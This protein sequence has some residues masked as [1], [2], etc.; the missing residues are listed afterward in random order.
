MF[1]AWYHHSTVTIH[2][3]KWLSHTNRYH[4]QMFG[5]LKAPPIKKI[6]LSNTSFNIKVVSHSSAVF[7]LL[8]QTTPEF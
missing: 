8:D 1:I 5:F 3:L 2:T 7:E 6:H 4:T